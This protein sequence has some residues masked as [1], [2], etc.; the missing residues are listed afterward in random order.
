MNLTTHCV[1]VRF[2]LFLFCFL[3]GESLRNLE[4]A[5]QIVSADALAQ[6]R[7]ELAETLKA[8]QASLD[9]LQAKQ[10]SK[11]TLYRR[12]QAKDKENQTLQEKNQQLIQDKEKIENKLTELEQ[13]AIEVKKIHQTNQAILRPARGVVV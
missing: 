11:S 1:I 5:K 10:M 2:A 6:D 4:M 3:E 13:H 8:T 7:A 12:L 9:A